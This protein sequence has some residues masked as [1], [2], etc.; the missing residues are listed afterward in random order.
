MAQEYQGKG[1]GTSIIQ[2]LIDWAKGNGVTTRIQLDTRTDNELAVKLYQSFGFG[3][4]NPG[5]R[6]G[7]YF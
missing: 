4:R 5:R 3:N 1:I 2:Q 6:S 7:A